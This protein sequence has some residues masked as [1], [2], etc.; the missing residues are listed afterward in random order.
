M[1][2]PLFTAEASLY[3]TRERY[4]LTAAWGAGSQAVIPQQDFPPQPPGGPIIR[5]GRCVE[6]RQV[7]CGGMLC[8]IRPCF[9]DL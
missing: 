3:K 2:T 4:Q 8:L 1:N 7:C 6:G 9:V 5:C